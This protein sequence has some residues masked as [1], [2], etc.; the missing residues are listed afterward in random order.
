MLGKKSDMSLL[1]NRSGKRSVKQSLDLNLRSEDFNAPC[2]P[3][4]IA[5]P[6]LNAVRHISHNGALGISRLRLSSIMRGTVN[7]ALADLLLGPGLTA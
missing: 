2:P 4:E 6:G 3:V 1:F 5:G 7:P